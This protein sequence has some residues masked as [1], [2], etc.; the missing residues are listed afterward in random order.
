MTAP[1]RIRFGLAGLGTQSAVDTAAAYARETRLMSRLAVVA[2][3]VGFDSVWT[4]EHHGAPDGY[5]PSPL[6]A[7][8]SIAATTT[9][10]RL[11]TN[12]ALA[13][14]YQPIRLAEDGAVL[15]Q[16]SGGRLILGLGLGYRPEEFAALGVD[17]RRRL[18][19]LR[20]A[21]RVLRQA[22][23]GSPVAVTPDLEVPVRPL[24][25]QAGGP[26]I[27]L[28][29][30]VEAAVRRAARLGDGYIAPVGTPKDIARRLDWLGEQGAPAGYPVAVSVNGFVGDW[31]RAAP[32]VD[33]MLAQYQR[34]YGDSGDPADTG[35][36]RITGSTP[37]GPPRHFVVGTPDEC[38]AQ[39]R[40]LCDALTRP[41]FEPHVLVRLA[42]PGQ[43]EEDAVA[44]V[45]RFGAEVIPAL[46]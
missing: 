46:R 9:R 30:W 31:S 33:H 32:G 43:S 10:V 20:D 37:A 23:S 25:L 16:L 34:W 12:I 28:G 38:V 45:R 15:D 14:L 26:P 11:G 7:L 24:P 29:G 13:P 35:R 22:W 5:L 6:V 21:V 40:P 3:E 19:L 39:L 18:A 17:V 2:E 8:A 4:T 1:A 44:S 36:G 41:G 42:Y 27:W